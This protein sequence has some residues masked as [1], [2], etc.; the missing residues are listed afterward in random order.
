MMLDKLL[1]IFLFAFLS[2]SRE[3]LQK[4]ATQ[5]RGFSL[6]K[7]SQG[8]ARRLRRLSRVMSLHT[9]HLAPT[10]ERLGAHRRV[11]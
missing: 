6:G 2:L 4:S 5:G 9:Q 8:D 7:P 11:V 1:F 10:A 3:K